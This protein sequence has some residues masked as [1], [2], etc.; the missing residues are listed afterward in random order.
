MRPPFNPDKEF[1]C[2]GATVVFGNARGRQLVHETPREARAIMRDSEEDMIELHHIG[3]VEVP[4][5]FNR[6]EIVAILPYWDE[7]EE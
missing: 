6:K 1:V 7:V 5:F 2:V 4:C 3:D